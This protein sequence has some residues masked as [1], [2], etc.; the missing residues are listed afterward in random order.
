MLSKID[1]QDSIKTKKIIQVLMKIM[2]FGLN[3]KKYVIFRKIIE[4]LLWI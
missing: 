3:N 2:K 1:N 4:K